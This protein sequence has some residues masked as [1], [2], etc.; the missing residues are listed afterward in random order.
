MDSIWGYKVRRNLFKSEDDYFRAN[1]HVSGMAAED[2]SII[3][4]PYSRGVNFDAV[5]RNEAARLW[6][7]ENKVVPRFNLTPEQSAAF[8]GSAYEKDDLAAKHSILGRIISE[9]PSAGM[10]T[11]MQRQWADWL[12]RQLNARQ[13]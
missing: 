5:G 8:K 10:V 1:P 7:R 6:L 4:N 13:R 9:D 2:N 3:L 11:P 12:I